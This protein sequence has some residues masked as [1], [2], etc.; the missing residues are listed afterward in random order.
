MD[1]DLHS[2]IHE[3][4]DILREEVTRNLK[5]MRVNE[6]KARELLKEQ[7]LTLRFQIEIDALYEENRELLKLNKEAI[8]IQ[9]QLVNFLNLR[10]AVKGVKGEF[11]QP[12][13]KLQNINE[14][15]QILSET[16]ISI[17]V[18]N[19]KLLQNETLSPEE[20]FELT[21][22]QEMVYDKNHPYWNDEK[23][24]DKLLAYYTEQEN[25]EMCHL[26]VKGK[27]CQ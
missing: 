11:V 21:I 9:L 2:Q 20:I 8:N 10:R 7:G 24:Y 23:F 12:T 19:D 22:K 6:Q 1:S 4:I 5:R 13:K 26:L 25:Y 15:E 27:Q 16:I 3:I 18:N 14:L 17:P